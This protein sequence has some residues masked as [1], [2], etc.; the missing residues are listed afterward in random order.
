MTSGISRRESGPDFFFSVNVKLRSRTTVVERGVQSPEEDHSEGGCATM[1]TPSI[2]RI[3][4]TA[5]RRC[6]HD[7]MPHSYNDFKRRIHLRLIQDSPRSSRRHRVGSTF[8]SPRGYGETS[9][10]V[11]IPSLGCS[12]FGKWKRTRGAFIF[13]NDESVAHSCHIQREWFFCRRRESC[14]ADPTRK[15]FFQVSRG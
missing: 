1:T 12:G 2:L 7:A 11:Y 4:Q 15:G 5:E 6:L 9:G 13:S 10:N 3:S 8:N 14:D